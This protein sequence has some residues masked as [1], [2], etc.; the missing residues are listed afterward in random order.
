MDISALHISSMSDWLN[1]IWHPETIG[2]P[3]V[4]TYLFQVFAMVACDQI[5]FSRNKAFHEG[6]GPNALSVSSTVNQVSK[7]HFFA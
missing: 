7:T 2:I 6:L 1:I 5:W 3:L 4:D